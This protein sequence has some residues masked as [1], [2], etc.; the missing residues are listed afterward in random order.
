MPEKRVAGS[1]LPR[2]DAVEKVRGQAIFGADFRLPGQLVGKFLPAPLAHAEILSIDTSRAAALPGVLAVLTGQD[3]PTPPSYDP[4]ARAFA[5][6]ARRYV[7]FQGQ[8]VAAVA[9]V[10]L[11]TAEQA[12]DLIAVE[13]APLPVV[14][15][16]EAA[17]AP[18]C[19]P[20]S[21][22]SLPGM[23]GEPHPEGQPPNVAQAVTYNYGD[24]EA[25][26]READLVLEQTYTVP[27]VHQSYLEPHTVTAFWDGPNHVTLWEPVQGAFAARSLISRALG[28][29]QSSVTIHTTEVGGAFGGKID[30]L[31][32]PI[33]AL[34]AKKARRP[35]QIVL[36]RH[37]ELVGADP[38][39]HSVI[40]LKTGVKRDGT[41]TAIEGDILLDAGAFPSG[42]IMGS[43]TN[44]IRNSYRFPAWRLKGQE[45]LTNKAPIGSYRAPGAPNGA[46][47][48]ESQMDEMARQ[49][50][51]D[52]L[53]FRM[54]NLVQEGDLLTNAEPQ[55]RTGSR[56]VLEALV[57]SGVWDEKPPERVGSD[58]LLHGRGLALGGWD[59][60]GGPGSVVA[61]LDGD[62][63]YRFILA[64]VDLTGSF[65][66]LAQIAAQELEVSPERVLITKASTDAA[67]FAPES[68]GSQTIIAM[69]AAV[70]I[71][72][73]KLKE[74]VLRNTAA[75]LSVGVDALVVSDEGISIAGRPE[76]RLTYA[77]IYQSGT[78]WFASSGPLVE[79]G[80]AGLRKP[81]PGYAAAVA[82]VVIDPETG[83]VRLAR[84]VTAQDV[85]CAINPLSVEGQ[86]QGAS[87]QSAGMALWEEVQYDDQ[88]RVRN[89]GL[90]DY[91]LPTAGDVPGIETIIVEVATGDGPYGSKVV[92]ETPMVPPAAAIANA[93]ASAIGVR[94]CDLPITPERVWKALSS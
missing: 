62:G 43:I 6:L 61:L 68:S 55:V 35:V 20:V 82:E 47:A 60:G 52:P 63:R 53:V 13:Y 10:D 9:A 94:I 90:L 71:A 91:R 18:G 29:P 38:A 16:P 7:V 57:T 67:P 12:L 50:G 70:Q 28:I 54:M 25:G 49:L 72:A 59:G 17:I 80:S 39:P 89:P 88:C 27:V 92:G 93:V 65:T 36:T 46:F 79:T 66:S 64:T 23:E 31:F 11:T 21:R 84:L 77:H 26:F 41:L 8:P 81:A 40:H 74:K 1:A 58:G 78:E 42:W 51:M 85:G 30:G 24:L 73:Q 5:S 15:S 37:E 87:I 34:L 2:I 14:A 48:M 56:E 44:S 45:V 19:I 86:I 76:T 83:L 75:S 22:E 33:A 3:L 69:G 4:G 32:A